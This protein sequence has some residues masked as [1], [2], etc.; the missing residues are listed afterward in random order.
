MQNHS[1]SMELRRLFEVF[2]YQLNSYPRKKALSSVQANDT[3]EHFS[4]NECVE[5]INQLAVGFLKLGLKRG[6]RVGIFGHLGNPGWC[7]FDLAAQKI[8]LVVVPIHKS[9]SEDALKYILQK[10]AIK[11]CLV[12]NDLL[13]EKI[14][15]NSTPD[16]S[17]IHFF[18]LDKKGSTPHWKT[19]QQFSEDEYLEMIQTLNA[20]IHEDDLATIIFT[21]GT[22]DH[23]KGVMLSHKNIVSNIKSIMTLIPINSEKRVVSFLPMSHIFERMVI[24][25]YVTV[26]ASIYFLNDTQT[27]L[28]KIKKVK[29]HYFTCVPRFL[30]RFYAGIHIDLNKRNKFFQRT[31]RWAILLG[32]KNFSAPNVN[33]LNSIKLKIADILV[34]RHWRKSLGNH[35]EGIVVGAAAM[36]PHLGRLFDA[37]KI[38][39]REGYGLTETA[40]VVSFNRFEPGGF[41]F[42]TVGIPVP[43]VDIKI[44][45]E[46]QGIG[47]IMVKGPNVM[48]GYLDDTIATRKV[49]DEDG[50]LKTGDVGK[51]VH[52][53]FLQISDRKKV[54][55]KT[56]SGKY[57]SPLQIE[58]KLQAST[59][60]DRCLI[61]GFNRPFVAALIIP[62]FERLELWCIENN[63]HWTAPQFMV[64]NHKIIQHYES[65]I[66]EINTQL[67]KSEKIR[68]I[69]LLFEPWTVENGELTTTLKLVRRVIEEKSKA[70]IEKMYS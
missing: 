67:T 45:E 55:F 30:E 58:N 26:G 60:I 12:E 50:W 62:D 35:V 13:K 46:D 4:T 16:L 29:P 1:I 43:G 11:V 59:F 70:L 24:Y 21:S 7:L 49:L 44:E 39:I 17:E 65:I 2:D 10:T 27:V 47:E 37:A 63:I 15:K 5:T 3:W 42:G 64:I 9:V 51:I 53:R 66:S 56:S 22:T 68:K 8:G 34:Y 54:I 61:I 69:H 33:L 25:L 48:M 18:S 52:K 6:E 31:I 41:R 28:P 23:P 57:I 14:N 32:E 36:P 40:P 38:K 20:V 19:L